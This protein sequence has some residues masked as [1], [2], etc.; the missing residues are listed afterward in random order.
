MTAA[1]KSRDSAGMTIARALVADRERFAKDKPHGPYTLGMAARC[2]DGQ[3]EVLFPPTPKGPK[4]VNGRDLLFDAIC[5][6]C[7][8][9]VN[10][11]S[12]GAAKTIGTAKRD[13]LI[14]S[15]DV[16]AEEIE[17]RGRAYERKYKD[18]TLSPM[19]LANHWPEFGDGRNGGR[20]RTTSTG[21][22]LYNAPLGWRDVATERFAGTFALTEML[23]KEWHDLS[24]T[25]REEILKAL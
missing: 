17:R 5:A 10:S 4:R 25:V 2:I 14:A 13:I 20:R 11:L 15:P 19:A 21:P 1:K 16:T 8:M 6:A 22:S 7:D 23:A 12:P 3:L 24:I 9:D 18:C